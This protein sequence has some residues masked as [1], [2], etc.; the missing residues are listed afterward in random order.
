MGPEEGWWGGE[1]PPDAPQG[2]REVG[3]RKAVEVA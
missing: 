2:K 1:S 3:L